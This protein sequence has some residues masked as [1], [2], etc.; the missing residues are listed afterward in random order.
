[1]NPL[2]L[3]NLT[4][5]FAHSFLSSQRNTELLIATQNVS[6]ASNLSSIVSGLQAL[7][8]LGN[9]FRFVG[10]LIPTRKGVQFADSVALQDA[11]LRNFPLGENPFSSLLSSHEDLIRRVQVV[12]QNPFIADT[13]DLFI[14]QIYPICSLV[15]NSA[16]IFCLY[17][18]VVGV[19]NFVYYNRYYSPFRILSAEKLNTTEKPLIFAC[20][21][22]SNRVVC[23]LPLWPFRPSYKI[24]INLTFGTAALLLCLFIVCFLGVE[25]S[26]LA[27]FSMINRVNLLDLQLGIA[28]RLVASGSSLDLSTFMGLESTSSSIGKVIKNSLKGIALGGLWVVKSFFSSSPPKNPPKAPVAAFSAVSRTVPT[29]SLNAESSSSVDRNRNPEIQESGNRNRNSEIQ[30][31]GNPNPEIRDTT[32]DDFFPPLKDPPPLND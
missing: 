15:I 5:F 20:G 19:A 30:E 31:S 24:N 11:S 18:L 17:M 8:L 21:W 10:N 4:S 14:Q 26:C 7:P 2:Q 25:Y 23:Y 9:A 29:R 22:Y 1:M 16:E 28:G 32:F 13:S 3:L 12:S 27:V 6:R